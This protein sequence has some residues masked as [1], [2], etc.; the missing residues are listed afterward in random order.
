LKVPFLD[1]RVLDKGL[2]QRLLRRVDNVFQH[3]R[4]IEGPEQHTLEE[5]IADAVG[6]RHA[7]GVSSGSSALY[8]ALRSLRVGEG[9]EVITTPFTWIISTHA[10]ASVGA[11]PV[12]VDV[13]S[14]GNIDVDKIEEAITPKTKAILPVHIGG[15]LCNMKAISGI[16]RHHKLKIVED[17]AQ[18]FCADVGG[19]RAGSFSDAAAFS[20][21]PMKVLFGYGEA[22]AVTTNQL[23]V[24]ERVR[25]LRH[26]GTTKDPRGRRINISDS[27]SLNHKM[28]TVQAALISESLAHIDSVWQR[29]ERV[30]QMY[31]AELGDKI[32]SQQPAEDEKHGRYLYLATCRKRNRLQD[33]L[34]DAGIESRSFYSPLTPNAAVY[35]RKNQKT[36]PMARKLERQMLALPLHEKLSDAQVDFVI[37]KIKAFYSTK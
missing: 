16:A 25:R 13:G 11:I 32:S 37:N 6:V 34:Q 14:D 7:I 3:G 36:F 12:F 8:L 27:V 35:R 5:E 4:L 29:R 22:G 9:D 18:A 26:A 28:D 10:V 33:F 15:H 19:R 2:R 30:A 17:A 21:N 31:D 24:D 23:K 1:L 20:F